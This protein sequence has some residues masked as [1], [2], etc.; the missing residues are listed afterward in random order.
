MPRPRRHAPLRVLLNNRLVGQL[1]KAATGAIDFQYDQSW[2]EWEHAL[3]VSLSLP[4]R[5]DAYRGEAVT[6]VFEN[7]LPDSTALRRRVAEKVGAAGT[8]AYSLLAAI[9][10][11]CVGA[12]QFIG[13]DEADE[14][15][16]GT[17]RGQGVNEVAIE[18][19]LRNL[20]QAPLGL[21]H[22]DAFRISVAGAQEKTALLRHR[23]RWLKP[24]GTTPTTHILKKQ[25]GR[26][27]NGIDLSN[28]VENEF[29]CLKLAD[30]FG[31]PVNHAEI[32]TFGKTKALVIERFDRRW[33]KDKRLLR[34]PQEDCC[35][36]LSIPPTR[37]YQSEGGP[38]LVEI[39]KLLKGSDNPDADRKLVLKAQIY[40]WLI[41]AT[42]GHAKNFS[43]FLGPGGR[44]HLTP[45]Y[46]VLTAQPSLDNGQIQRKQMKLSMSVGINRH[47]RIHEITGR[48]FLQ[49]GKAAGLSK[50]VVLEM[51]EEM[52]DTTLQAMEKVE[53]ELPRN[54]PRSLH[55]S[56]KK[57]LTGRLKL[58]MV[59]S[60]ERGNAQLAR[61]TD[62]KIRR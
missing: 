15:S 45:L 42:D 62:R 16:P 19:L 24:L 54:F 39:L 43:I 51:M 6:A 61:K 27:P 22:D 33:T 9:G 29:Y 14:I 40:F 56:A 30:A 31:L 13:L 7:L 17:V 44:F 53:N 5:D 11:D 37:K 25:I 20:S 34:L 4:L 49:T 3:P 1:T 28:S 41:G 18:K 58:L 32:H 35:Q 47:Y 2:L 57:G 8:D 23:G 21:S 46:D 55:A 12:L 52:A 50:R 36:A 48:H 10:R 26:L 38:G 60:G 59:S